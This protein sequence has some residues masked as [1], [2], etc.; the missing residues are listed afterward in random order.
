[1]EE[2]EQVLLLTD[3]MAA[4]PI[5]LSG[6]TY[7]LPIVSFFFVF[8]LIYALLKKTNILGDNNWVAVFISFLLAASFIAR[9]SLVEFVS[10]SSA[11]FVVFLVCIFMILF[12][13]AFT[14]GKID[15]VMKPWVAWA[16]LVLLIAF[17][18]ISSAY[19]FNWATNWDV[20]RSWAYTD[21]FGM[22]VLVIIAAF[23]SWMLTKK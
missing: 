9:A 19:V 12:M 6:L 2:K 18:V 7:F 1:M 17:F 15:V 20:I 8:V 16:I 13:I 10:F 14:H 21:W 3:N 22:V 11:W 5:S 4:D 23:V